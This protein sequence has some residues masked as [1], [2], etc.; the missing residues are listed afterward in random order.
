MLRSAVMAP[1]RR[2]CADPASRGQGLR[3]PVRRK[4]QMSGPRRAGGDGISHDIHYEGL[5]GAV[6]TFPKRKPFATNCIVATVKTAFADFIVQQ[7]EGK[8]TVDTYDFKRTGVFTAFGFAYLGIAQ[9]FVYV[10][11]FT[12]VC[13]NAVRFSNLPW[14]EKLKDKAGQRDLYKQVFLDNFVHYTFM[15]FPVFY[16][17]K[18]SIKGQGEAKDI[19]NA[20]MGKYWNNCVQ[21]N[22]AIWGLWIPMDLII[23][24]VP[25]WMRLPLN[26][27]VS[28][29]WTMILSWM[30]GDEK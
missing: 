7:G 14:A 25:V 9:W 1:A 28:F 24:A 3:A 27:A 4:C 5:W 19:V 2:F 17:F 18:E 8:N 26:H 16:I 21:D 30:R 11:V 22:L 10:T 20:A 23:Y 12:R 13:P 6:T 15:Y 29:A